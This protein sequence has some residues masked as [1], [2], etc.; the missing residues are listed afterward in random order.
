MHDRF[1]IGC[2]SGT[3]LDG[4]DAALI[5]ISGTG[6]SLRAGFIAADSA[7][8]NDLAPRLRAIASQQPVTAGD[9]ARAAADLTSL[10]AG[11]CTRLWNAHAPATAQPGAQPHQ[12]SRPD[13]L[14][15]APPLVA[16]HAARRARPRD[17]R[18]GRL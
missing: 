6:P 10:H 5:Q 1:I 11:L 14:P 9:I 16:T 15:S 2:M 17:A 8:F 18:P 7:P 4:L 13:T 12:R 3:S